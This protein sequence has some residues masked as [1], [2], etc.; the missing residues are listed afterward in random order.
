MIEKR[1]LRAMAVGCG[2]AVANI[3]YAQPLLNLLAGSF[4]TSEGAVTVVV[5]PENVP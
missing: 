3:Y 1:T 4:R 2:L 5:V